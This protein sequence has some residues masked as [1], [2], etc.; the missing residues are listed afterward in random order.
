MAV[1]QNQISQIF[2]FALEPSISNIILIIKIS[3]IDI[4]IA[5]HSRITRE[6]LPKTERAM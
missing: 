2:I 6:N 5:F 4:A 3:I 1:E